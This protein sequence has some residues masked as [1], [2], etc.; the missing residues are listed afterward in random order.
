MIIVSAS[1][2]AINL[3]QVQA[4]FISFPS[5]FRNIRL[6]VASYDEDDL[7]KFH[8]VLENDIRAKL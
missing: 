5:H 6:F 2:N 8:T 1:I 3:L 4:L 7:K